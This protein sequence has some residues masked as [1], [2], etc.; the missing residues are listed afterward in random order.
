MLVVFRTAFGYLGRNDAQLLPC[1]KYIHRLAI[2]P[3]RTCIA[4]H[5]PSYLTM[6][7]LMLRCKCQTNQC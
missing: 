1:V 4:I 7:L 3:S 6:L 5:S 2:E